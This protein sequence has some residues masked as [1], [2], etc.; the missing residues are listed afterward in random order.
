[1]I[2]LDSSPTI[3]CKARLVLESDGD[4]PSIQ[5]SV[6]DYREKVGDVYLVSSSKKTQEITAIDSQS[7]PFTLSGQVPE[8]KALQIAA[9]YKVVVEV[10]LE[11][12]LKGAWDKGRVSQ[13]YVDVSILS[14]VEVWDK[15]GHK[16]YPLTNGVAR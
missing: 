7:G 10:R 4:V 15:P 13:S 14:I 16:V 2:S 3:N 9:A 12:K 5:C 1:M 6:T 11:A 8:T